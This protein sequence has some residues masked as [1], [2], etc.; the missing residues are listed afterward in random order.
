MPLISN[1]QLWNLR[2]TFPICEF[3][4]A[5][6]P[7]SRNEVKYAPLSCKPTSDGGISCLAIMI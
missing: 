5:D 6:P 2:G 4:K 1:G 3:V 7:L